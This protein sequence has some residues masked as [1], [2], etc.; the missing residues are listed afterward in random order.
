MRVLLTHALGSGKSLSGIAAAESRGEPYTAFAPAALRP[1]YRREIGR[2]TDQTVPSAVQSYS[3]LAQGKPTPYLGT[4]IFDEAHN[5]RNPGSLRSRRAIE[6][7]DKAN[8]VVLLSGT[9]VVHRPGDLAVPIRMLTGRSM[10]PDEFEDRYVTSRPLYT[11]ALRRWFNR[12]SGTEPEIANREELKNL[13]AGRVDFHDP[14]RPVVPTT[15]VDVPVDMSDEQARL[16]RAVWDTMPPWVRWRLKHDTDM[17]GPELRRTVSFLTGPRQISLSTYPY[18]KDKNPLRAFARSPKLVE[19][20]NRLSEAFKDPRA[21][22]LVFSN[23]IDA[24]LIPYSAQLTATK[25]P[26]ATFHGGLS[27]AERRKL[28]EDYNTGRIRVALLGPSGTEGL[29]FKGTQLVQLLDPHFG[30]VRAHQSIGRAL[31][32]DSHLDLP[33]ELQNV[34]VERYISRLPLSLTARTL[35]RLGLH[36]AEHKRLATDD[37]LLAMSRRKATLNRKFMDLL[38]EVGT[39]KPAADCW[40]EVL[41]KVAEIDRQDRVPGYVR[42]EVPGDKGFLL[43]HY[44]RADKYDHPAGR[45]EPG[46]TPHTAAVRELRERTGYEPHRP[47]DLTPK[48]VDGDF[49]VFTVP[50][51]GLR[52]VAKPGE[53][54]GYSTDVVFGQPHTPKV[55]A[56]KIPGGLADRVPRSAFDPAALAE[57]RKVEAEHTSDPAVADEIAR[58]HLALHSVGRYNTQS[59]SR[60]IHEGVTGGQESVQQKAAS[61]RVSSVA[62]DERTLLPQERDLL[63]ELRR[64]RH[65]GVSGVVEFIRPLLSGH[66]TVPIWVFAGPRKERS[67]VL[68]GELSLGD[69]YGTSTQHTSQRVV[70]VRRTEDAGH[71][72]GTRTERESSDVDLSLPVGGTHDGGS[73]KLTSGAEPQLYGGDIVTIAGR[74]GGSVGGTRWQATTHRGVGEV[75]GNASRDFE[76]SATCGYDTSG[77][78]TEADRLVSSDALFQS[79]VSTE[80]KDYY[81]KLKKMEGGKAAAGPVRLSPVAAA[82][83]TPGDF[84]YSPDDLKKIAALAA[85]TAPPAVG[86]GLPVMD[87]ILPGVDQRFRDIKLM[88]DRGDYRG[89]ASAL[90]VLIQQAPRAWYVDSDQGYTVGLTHASGWRYH[91]PRHLVNDLIPHMGR[92]PQPGGV[93]FAGGPPGW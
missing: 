45:I 39:E 21:K 37:Y 59:I 28:V 89:K 1:N 92:P 76:R 41:T 2:F 79:V 83:E 70:G 10:T 25:V 15:H 73:S 20:H 93:P 32:F 24:G 68:S 14:G 38:R 60:V 57:G 36:S 42:I 77:G 48:G 72:L 63:Q 58:D 35:S 4:A 49:H 81:K 86:G 29:S 69:T 91:V 65:H 46:E 56:D 90:R 19:A 22:A 84:T 71:R 26:H 40:F 82:R 9:P 34:R 52:Q 55:A 31:R 67:T 3:E 53:L 11:S 54:G 62:G 47:T 66:G 18:A 43:H 78:T 51:H 44:L 87:A 85:L 61:T 50:F 75:D 7:A 6:V 13:L 17:T 33:P 23:F 16:Y 80:D 12:P 5:L 30:P 88:S 64:P 27:D 8:Q 74:P